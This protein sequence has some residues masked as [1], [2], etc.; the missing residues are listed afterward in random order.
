LLRWS[1]ALK[2]QLSIKIKPGNQELSVG[3]PIG[4]V[5]LIRLV[6]YRR[7]VL[8]AWV[9]AHVGKCRENFK[10]LPSV[11]AREVHVP[12]PLKV[13]GQLVTEFSAATVRAHVG[14]AGH[15]CRWLVFGEGGS[16]KTSLACRMARWALAED[17]AQR[18][19]PHLMLPVL[20]EDELD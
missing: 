11:K 8:D 20:I 7:R 9:K 5:S 6:A 15:Q 19:A 17:K 18:L 1:D 12:S 10:E 2:D 16:G 3:V 13:D 4:Y 14:R